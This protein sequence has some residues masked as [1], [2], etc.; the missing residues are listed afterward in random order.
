[1]HLDHFS[2]VMVSLLYTLSVFVCGVSQFF[3]ADNLNFILQAFALH[4]KHGVLA[5]PNGGGGWGSVPQWS[6]LGI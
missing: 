5:F 1:M 6:V 4:V 2:L 3:S